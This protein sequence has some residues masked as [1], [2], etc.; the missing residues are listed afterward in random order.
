MITDKLKELNNLLN[1]KTDDSNNKNYSYSQKNN[2]NNN[3]VYNILFLLFIYSVVSNYVKSTPVVNH[4]SSGNFY[5]SHSYSYCY[6][7]QNKDTCDKSDNYEDCH[8]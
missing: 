6:I 3:A 1:Q 4:G 7:N 2:Y 5:V 8:E